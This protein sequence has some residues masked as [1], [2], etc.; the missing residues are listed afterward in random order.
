M[1]R[2]GSRIKKGSFSN[3]SVTGS[4]S[5]RI[6]ET[7]SLS[8]NTLR[9]PP[10]SMGETGSPLTAEDLNAIKTKHKFK[11]HHF[12]KPTWCSI[13]MKFIWGVGKQGEKCSVCNWR[14]HDKCKKMAMNFPCD[15]DIPSPLDVANA[16]KESRK[17]VVVVGRDG[18]PGRRSPTGSFSKMKNE[19]PIAQT[20]TS[21]NLDD[22]LKEVQGD[23]GLTDSQI[24]K[25]T[26]G[27]RSPTDPLNRAES[28]LLLSPPSD[29]RRPTLLGSAAGSVQAPQNQALVELITDET[30]ANSR[31]ADCSDTPADW[32]STN[33]GVFICMNCSGSHRKVGTHISKVLSVKLDEWTWDQVYFMG[34]HGNEKV[35]EELKEWIPDVTLVPDSS[36]ELRFAYILAKYSREPFVAPAETLKATPPSFV[37]GSRIRHR[38]NT[39]SPSKKEQKGK[40]GAQDSGSGFTNLNAS[41]VLKVDVVCGENLKACDVSGLSDPYCKLT[42]EDTTVKTKVMRK[43]LNPRWD[44][45]FM[46][47]VKD[48][49]KAKWIQVVVYDHDNIGKDDAMGTFMIS[50][51]KLEPEKELEAW[52][53]V[54]HKAKEFGRVQVRLTYF[55][56]Q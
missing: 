4:S 31:C 33:L 12:H 2:I 21:A 55:P 35:N 26:T 48:V 17:A 41:G 53:R 46:I 8:G 1:S 44:E 32:A 52:H 3:P 24:L 39:A 28:A 45:S 50:L 36:L 22:Y 13:C 34:D 18:T 43:D 23:T 9:P 54:V 30:S 25:I 56:L 51:A 16:E 19:K 15:L 42:L 6:V 38:A 29:G 27:E 14:V 10:S 7:T 37:Q 11:R 47:N 20:T 49:A 40:G 5:P